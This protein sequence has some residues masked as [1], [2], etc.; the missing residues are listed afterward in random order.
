MHFSPGG[1]EEWEGQEGQEGLSHWGFRQTFNIKLLRLNW[2]LNHKA[3]IQHKHRRK[4][5][6]PEFKTTKLKALA[7]SH[8]N[9]I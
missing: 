4:T 2:T 9:I 6:Q 8:T 3:V 7:V 5:G 1:Q